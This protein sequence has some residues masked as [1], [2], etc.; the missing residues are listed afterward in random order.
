MNSTERRPELPRIRRYTLNDQRRLLDRAGHAHWPLIAMI[1]RE[2]PSLLR[3]S[4]ERVFS[5]GA[6]EY[7]D[8]AW[9]LSTDQLKDEIRQELADAFFYERVYQLKKKR[10]IA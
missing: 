6:A 5:L 3:L 1:G 7:G 8:A 9:H 4:D 10:V 2:A